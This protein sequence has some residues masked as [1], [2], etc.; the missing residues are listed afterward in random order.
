MFDSRQPKLS[1]EGAPAAV[2]EATVEETAVTKKRQHEA[3]QA[4]RQPL[5]ISKKSWKEMTIESRLVETPAV[6]RS[7]GICQRRAQVK[8]KYTQGVCSRSVALTGGD[9]FDRQVHPGGDKH[10]F[11]SL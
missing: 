3:V 10:I 8:G 5:G 1:Q 11:F 7:A 9:A 4:R 6:V 2:K